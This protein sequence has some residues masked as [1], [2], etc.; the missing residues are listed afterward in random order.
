[1]V[2]KGHFWGSM[3]LGKKLRASSM[4]LEICRG[5]VE[6]DILNYQLIKVE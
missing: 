3:L 2:Y 6:L 4:L 5:H 1:M